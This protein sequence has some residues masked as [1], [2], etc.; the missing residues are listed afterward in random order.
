MLSLIATLQTLGFNLKNRLAS[1]KGATAVEYGIMV[2]LIAVVIIVA[3]STLGGTLGDF[4]D[5]INLKLGKPT[6]A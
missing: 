5:S 1:E 2:G 6:P 3:V 4:F